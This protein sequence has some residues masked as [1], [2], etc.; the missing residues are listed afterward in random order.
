[1]CPAG[2]GSGGTPADGLRGALGDP[3]W[4]SQSSIPQRLGLP[5][6]QAG[7]PLRVVHIP[8]LSGA[9]ALGPK[10]ILGWG[11]GISGLVVRVQGPR[12]RCPKAGAGAG[13]LPSS[14]RLKAPAPCILVRGVPLTPALQAKDDVHRPRV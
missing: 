10:L 13:P 4:A 2:E 1:M 8:H 11:L 3:L 5:A 9:R 6:S 12:G 7:S 14:S